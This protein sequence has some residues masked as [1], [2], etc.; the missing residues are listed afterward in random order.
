MALCALPLGT[1]QTLL[2]RMKSG[3]LWIQ[4][5]ADGVWKMCKSEG[6]YIDVELIKTLA[7]D[8]PDGGHA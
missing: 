4:S 3:L 6:S 1:V 5:I 8:R 2:Q 7:W